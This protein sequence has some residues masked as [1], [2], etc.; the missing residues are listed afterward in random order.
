MRKY[1]DD[2]LVNS[3]Y[4]WD[5]FTATAM[6]QYLTQIE[7]SFIQE[8]LLCFIWLSRQLFL[9][10]EEGLEDLQFRSTEMDTG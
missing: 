1:V 9:M 2:S 8:S 3:D 10:L 6:G 4:Y 7:Q 5:R